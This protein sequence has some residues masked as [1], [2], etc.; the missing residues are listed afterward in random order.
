MTDR[1]KE[2]QK[3]TWI[4]FFFNLFLS[5]A[6]LIA[7]LI[8]NSAA[9]VADAIHSISDFATD[10]IVLAFVRISDKGGDEDHKY[11]HGKFETFATLLISLALVF[12]GIGI[13]YN[14]FTNVIKSLK[15]EILEQPSIIALIAAI[16]SIIV[17]EALFRYTKKVGND[18][19]NQAVVAN[20]WHHRSDAFSSIGTMLGIGG[21]IFLGEK[22]RLLDPLAG[23]IVS[24][25]IIKV[26]IELGLPSVKEL[27][28]AALPEETEKEILSIIHFNPEVKDSHHLKTRKIGNI[29]AID[30]HIKLDRNIS[31]I[32]SHDIATDIEIRLRERYGQRTQINIHTEPYKEKM[33]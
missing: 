23:F 18:I 27:L 25:F 3:V 24:F 6:K 22:W 8:G 19:N 4:G 32:E 31:F 30:I 12:V 2:A 15:G 16:V 33:T 9:M 13:G 11:G 5:A 26:A 21:A 17:K 20:A 7:G 10:I 14:G 28:E 29:F 1:T